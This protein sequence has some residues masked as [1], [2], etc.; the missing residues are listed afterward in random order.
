MKFAKENKPNSVPEGFTRELVDKD[1]QKIARINA[2]FK[3]AREVSV[4]KT[5]QPLSVTSET[6]CLDYVYMNER[7]QRAY[8]ILGHGP[9]EIDLTRMDKGMNLRDG[10]GG[11]QVAK[12]EGVAV[13]DG[14]LCGTSILW[15]SSERAQVLCAD[16]GKG[17]RDDVSVEADYNP[18]ALSIVGDRDG[19]PV[20]RCVRWTPL[21]AALG[22]VTA[23]DP[24]V[25]LNRQTPEAEKP[26]QPES[27][28]I[29]R[30]RKME[31]TAE[32]L[33]LEKM[34]NEKKI[35]R[36]R[37]SEIYAV[38]RHFNVPEDQTQKFVDGETPLADVQREVI[39]KFAQP[40]AQSDMNR[41]AAPAQSKE[42]VGNPAQ[43]GGRT[44][45]LSR[46]ILAACQA[47]D[48]SFHI[49]S[50]VDVGFEREMAKHAGLVT[51]SKGFGV[52]WDAPI[53][54][55]VSR[56]FAIT[57]P[58]TGSYVVSQT[59]RP[60]LFIDFLYARLILNKLG[61]TMLPG[62]VG[63]VLL[64]KQTAANSGGWVDETTGGT[65]GAPTLGQV[66]GTP[67]TVSA[68]TEITRQMLIQATPAA[69]TI[70]M[71]TLMNSMAR[72][73]Q[74]GAFEGSGTANQ[75][76][77][78]K[79]ALAAGYQGQAGIAEA[80]VSSS[81]NPTFAEIE[82]AKAIPEEANV[83][84]PFKFAMRPT[85]FRKLK[86]TARG[87]TIYV[88]VAVEE[89]D[90]KFVADSPTETTSALTAGYAYYGAF[91]TM[92]VA[93]WGSTDLIVN[94][95]ALDTAGGLRITALQSVDVLH[96]YLNAFAWSSKFG[97]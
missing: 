7:W 56:A 49:P 84:G 83:D 71:N 30:S 1:G 78:L 35:E 66:K 25:G 77:G 54:P 26:K 18:S 65:S 57:S 82:A 11:D 58:G 21:A 75:P 51:G 5:A 8:V 9:G 76:T 27:P 62:M 15:G 85:A 63:D 3:I 16:Y 32:E 89:G 42:I 45:S 48:P 24:N 67:H 46:A 87:T 39:A 59:L 44:Y 81:G 2:C 14:K 86:T 50:G 34:A 33:A 10:H 68:Y 55:R 80:T 79:T 53:D 52:P 60:D 37:V 6:P 91:E 72:T 41:V 70:V 43:H 95:Y 23:A 69:D 12:L 97:S 31:K 64:P 20:V 93:L 74:L 92:A 29:I 61:V 38:C 96:R 17:V 47:K 13:R 90:S 28:A 40:K 36:S 19:V 22:V 73:I 94:P 4:D 88:P